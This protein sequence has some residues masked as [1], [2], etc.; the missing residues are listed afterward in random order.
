MNNSNA[1]K[2]KYNVTPMGKPT[3]GKAH[4]KTKFSY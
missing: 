2:D 4:T 3:L 1:K